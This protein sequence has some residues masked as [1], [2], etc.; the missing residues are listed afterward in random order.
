LKTKILLAAPLL[1]LLLTLAAPGLAQEGDEGPTWEVFR[2]WE[3]LIRTPGWMEVQVTL[4]N[5]GSAWE[6]VLQIGDP[7]NEVDYRLPL[8]LPAHSRKQYRLPL[9]VSGMRSLRIAL[10]QGGRIERE[11]LLLHTPVVRT[12]RMR[13]ALTFFYSRMWRACRKPPWPGTRWT[14]CW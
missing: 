2:A 13:D 1:C 9:F 14:C 3:G 12:E 7:A 11:K 5:E 10:V 6:G 4:T 8:L